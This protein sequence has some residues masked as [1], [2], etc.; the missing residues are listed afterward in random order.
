MIFGFTSGFTSGT[1][2]VMV[3]IIIIYAFEV[4]LV[5]SAIMV[6]VMNI[7]FLL[8]KS[9]QFIV[10]GINDIITVKFFLQ[11]L[12]IVVASVIPLLIGM[13]VRD[14]IDAEAYKKIVKKVL[15]ILAIFLTIQY[16]I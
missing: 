2:S 6:Q 11:S 3:P 8:G 10:F 12:P 9:M 7:A 5:G 1:I 15:F 16:F 14:K 4:G 13:R